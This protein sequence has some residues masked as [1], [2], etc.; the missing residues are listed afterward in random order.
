MILLILGWHLT[1]IGILAIILSLVC[2]FGGMPC[3]IFG[4]GAF[5]VGL[6]MSILLGKACSDRSGPVAKNDANVPL[7]YY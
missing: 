3:L 2:G 4:L 7:D 1:V 6:P 5:A